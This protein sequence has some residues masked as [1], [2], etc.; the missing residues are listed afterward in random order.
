[1]VIRL[2]RVLPKRFEHLERLER[3][4]H[5]ERFFDDLNVLNP[6]N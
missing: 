5:L 4:E 3:L 1:M 6:E 2:N